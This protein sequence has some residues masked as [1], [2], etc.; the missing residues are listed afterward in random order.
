MTHTEVL[1][2]NFRC[3]RCLVNYQYP[4]L[5]DVWAETDRGFDGNET[6][7]CFDPHFVRQAHECQERQSDY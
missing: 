3:P 2:L 5:V 7:I 1:P 6:L 4:I